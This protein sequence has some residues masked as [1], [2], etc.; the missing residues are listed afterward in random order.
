MHL[1]S[2]SVARST[3]NLIHRPELRT[4]PI[5]DFAAR[6]SAPLYAVRRNKAAAGVWLPATFS[7]PSREAENVKTIT[8]F[9]VDSDTL[10]QGQLD[11]EVRRLQNEGRHFLVHSSHSYDPPNKSKVRFIFFLSE[12]IVV[13]TQWRWR[14]ALWP[15]LLAHTR[16]E[17]SADAACRD[18]SRAYYLPA[19]PFESSPIYSLY[20][21]GPNDIDVP[22]VLG[23]IL[24]QPEARYDFKRTYECRE[25]AAAPVDLKDVAVRMYLRYIRQVSFFKTIKQVLDG[26]ATAD[27]VGRHKVICNFTIALAAVAKPEESSEA[28]IHIMDPWLDRMVAE[29]GQRA[30]GGWH[31]EALKALRGAREKK[32]T[33]DAYELHQRHEFLEAMAARH[34]GGNAR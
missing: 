8:A 2:Y 13:G 16:L 21:C 32:P 15:A 34:R 17:T 4:E 30:G 23:A 11:A 29:Y 5:T 25:D 19:K 20:N 31:A 26:V 10:T 3:N 27:G 9:V 18:A 22:T 7:H 12:P 28:L 24:A 33:W 14:D 1:L 6:F